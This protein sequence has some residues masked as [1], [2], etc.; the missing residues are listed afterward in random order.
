MSALRPR[1]ARFAPLFAACALAGLYAPTALAAQPP[2][3]APVVAIAGGPPPAGV[4]RLH[5][6]DVGTG[7]SI[8]VEGHDFSLLYDAGSN[9]DD[10]LGPKDRVLAYLSAVRR[11]LTVLD[12]LILSHPHQDHVEMMDDVLLKYDVRN[13]WDSGSLNDT[14]GYRAFLDAVSAEPHVL[15]HDALGGGGTHDATFKKGGNIAC[16]GVRRPPATVRISRSSQISPTPI[17]LGAGATMTILRADGTRKGPSDFNAASVVVRLNLGPVSILLPGDSE[18]GE[19]INWVKPPK[20]GSVEAQLLAHPQDLHADL[21]IVGHHGSRTSSHKE[22][23]DAVG[24]RRFIVSVGPKAYSGTVLP[25]QIVMNELG[26]RGSVWRT[27]LHDD[28]CGA[29]TAKVGRDADGQP[30]GCDNVLV[31]IDSTG[32]VSADYF[33]PAD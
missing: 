3:P 24:A 25:D 21:L 10:G 26:S 19:R 6:I 1:W 12:H 2:A 17:A 32:I 7:L 13:V 14:C 27:N 23:L 15:Y 9:D 16:H 29:N 5:A 11:D 33:H 18:G 31:T 20:A 22:F 28:T 8:F 4:F 30:G